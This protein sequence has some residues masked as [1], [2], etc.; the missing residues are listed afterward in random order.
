MGAAFAQ[1]VEETSWATAIVMPLINLLI[2]P[3]SVFSSLDL[4][5]R[6]GFD[7]CCAEERLC[8]AAWYIFEADL[9]KGLLRSHEDLM[10]ARGGLSWALRKPLY[11]FKAGAYHC[12]R[13]RS[14]IAVDM[15]L[16]S[17]RA[18]YTLANARSGNFAAPDFSYE[19]WL[20]SSLWEQYYTDFSPLIINVEPTNN[21]N[22]DC[23]GCVN[24][25]MQRER[26]QL[27]YQTFAALI[28]EFRKGDDCRWVFSGMGEPLLNPE[29]HRMI[30]LAAP[31]SSMLITS[32]QKMPAGDFPYDALDHIR[33][34]TDALE[35]ESFEKLRP[36][37]SWSNIEN[38]LNLARP[39]KLADPQGFPEIGITMVRHA[40]TELQ[41]QPFINYW[42]QVAKPI[43][44]ENF[45]RWPFDLP[46]DRVQWYQILGEAS[47][48]NSRA[49]TSKV[50]FTPV[51]RRPCRNALLS[52]TVLSDGSVTVC[53]YDFEGRQVFGNLKEN[54]LR[55]IWNSEKYCSFRRRHL[56]LEF[57]D[58]KF[59]NNCSD[60]Y[61][62]I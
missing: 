39:Q 28:A 51:R 43:Y 49:R 27:S 7:F 48:N 5:K 30:T 34:S 59:C 3:S 25:Q 47:F 26:S 32:L 29:L 4:H 24:K 53:P 55:E 14:A 15:R 52:A 54:T 62:P 17:M 33:I 60:W 2:E 9:L 12:P 19:E 41:V 42:K 18:L 50:D 22:A 57:A 61:H 20:Y 44:R 56:A 8:G 45:F 11:P 40:E 23:Y 16:N 1:V 6:E 36:G 31:F 13:I 38:F 35:A 37:C 21:C 10:W 46:P 58:V